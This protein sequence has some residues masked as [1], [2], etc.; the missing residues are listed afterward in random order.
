MFATVIPI[1]RDPLS[2]L[3]R[4]QRHE[5][6]FSAQRPQ[7]QTHPWLPRSYGHQRRS[8]SYRPSPCPGPSSSFCLIRPID[9]NQD[10]PQRLPT[11]R[12]SFSR[13]QRLLCAADFKAVFDQPDVKASRQHGLLL[14]R[15]SQHNTSR[16]GLIIAKKNVRKAVERNRI[17]RLVREYFRRATHAQGN[18]DIIFLARRGIDNLDSQAVN[19]LLTKLWQRLEDSANR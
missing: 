8:S 9:A 1:L 15:A 16:L 4:C 6:H 17:K 14:A 3:Y 12:Q 19:V 18:F 11:P 5:T 2:S 10:R 7:A 13:E